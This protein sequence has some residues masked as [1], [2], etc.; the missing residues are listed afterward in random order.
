MLRPKMFAAALAAFTLGFA[1][2]APAEI[3]KV[4]PTHSFVT[5]E[6]SHLGFS[7]LQGRFNRL[8][9]QFSYDAAKPSESAISVKVDVAS[10]DTNHAERDKHLREKYLGVKD[11]PEAT[12]TSSKFV[13]DGSKGTLEGMLTLHGVTKPITVALDFIGAGDDPWGGYRRGY[14]GT[15]AIKRSDFGMTQSLGP[16]G[17]TVTL[18]FVIEG[19]REK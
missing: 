17:D 15:T 9:G 13:E 8:E 1:G 10:V 14:V 7:L 12:F 5:F 6:I 4:D 18:K 3:Y 19:I 2:N 16:Q 11:Y